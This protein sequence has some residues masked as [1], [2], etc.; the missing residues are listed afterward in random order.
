MSRDFRPGH[1]V[2]GL[3]QRCYQDYSP[4]T[5]AGGPGLSTRDFSLNLH[6]TLICDM[7][8]GRKAFGNVTLVP[9]YCLYVLGRCAQDFRPG[10]LVT[11]LW[12]R[13]YRDESPRTLE[14]RPRTIVSRKESGP[15][16]G[17]TLVRGANVGEPK[18]GA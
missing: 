1:Q 5:L 3:W 8:R 6:V 17:G 9:I 14:Q 13:C 2:T 15:R 18:P 11:G 4:R 12:Q 10:Y 7:A 16:H